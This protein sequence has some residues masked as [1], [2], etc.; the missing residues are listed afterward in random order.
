MPFEE[1]VVAAQL[2]KNASPYASVAVIP[3]GIVPYFTRLYTVDMLGK[4]DAHI[5][6][7]PPQRGAMVGHGKVDPAYSFA[8]AP[9]YVVSVRPRNFTV[10]ITP[11]AAG[12]TDYVYT[13]LSSLEFQKEWQPYPIF[14]PFLLEHSAVY[15]GATSPERRRVATWKG[16]AV[17]P[18]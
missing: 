16:V 1:I 14:D 10:G 5:A 17:G 7:L 2:L 11:I 4:T 15:V 9:D 13:I 12:T 8:K 3:V 6:Q 18:E